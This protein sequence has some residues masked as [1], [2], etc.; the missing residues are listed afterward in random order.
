VLSFRR[1]HLRW[2]RPKPHDAQAWT[3]TLRS[4]DVRAALKRLPIYRLT[5][6][7][8]P[9]RSRWRLQL[10]TLAGGVTV[11][12]FPP[13]ATPNPLLPQEADALRALVAALGR[14]A[15]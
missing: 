5:L 15:G 1:G 3:D 7:W 11:T 8:E 12:F 14:A 10:E 4:E 9:K 6:G 13:L 2:K